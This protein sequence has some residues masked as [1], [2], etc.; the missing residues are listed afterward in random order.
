VLEAEGAPDVL[1]KWAERLEESIAEAKLVDA[2]KMQVIGLN[3][4][5]VGLSDLGEL[6]VAKG[7]T[8]PM[9]R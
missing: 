2:Y 8:I 6:F 3:I 5:S 4:W 9:G 7:C 1:P